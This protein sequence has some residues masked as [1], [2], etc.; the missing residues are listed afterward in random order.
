[1]WY[2]THSLV[3][4]YVFY[5]LYFCVSLFFVITFS[6]P[7]FHPP[8]KQNQ[9]Q[10]LWSEKNKI[11]INNFEAKKTKS[12]SRKKQNQNQQLWSEKMGLS[13]G[14]RKSVFVR[15]IVEVHL[16]LLF[17]FIFILLVDISQLFTLFLSLS[18]SNL[19]LVLAL[20]CS[21]GSFIRYK[22]AKI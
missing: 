11:K 7:Y 19:K 14:K 10:Q 3:V 17:L 6:T 4:T 8:V 16:F 2:F 5:V 22:F 15:L 20:S 21:V 9:N 12:K 18:L 13:N 1:M